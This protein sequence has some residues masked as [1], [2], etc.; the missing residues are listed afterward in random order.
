MAL[1]RST[2]LQVVPDALPSP[3]TIASSIDALL[4]IRGGT[5]TELA[6]AIGM[7]QPAL[8]KRL[9]GDVAWKADDLHRIAEAFGVPIT[10]LYEGGEAIRARAWAAVFT[11]PTD[12]HHDGSHLGS[13]VTE[14]KLPEADPA[15]TILPFSA[16][17]AA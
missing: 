9:G 7:K 15:A 5:Q 17:R 11:R 6:M 4:D 12:P 13:S 2:L 14:R 16:P 10:M 3:A 1:T 8:S